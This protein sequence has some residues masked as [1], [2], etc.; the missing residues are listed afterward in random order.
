MTVLDVIFA[1]ISTPEIYSQQIDGV[2]V[3]IAAE[4][5]KYLKI[6]FLDTSQQHF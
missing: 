5:Q 3:K 4:I 2:E 6:F 1:S